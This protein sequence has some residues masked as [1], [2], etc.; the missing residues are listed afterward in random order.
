MH[1]SWRKR[2]SRTI[3]GNLCSLKL[4]GHGIG[5]ATQT[6]N[7]LLVVDPRDFGVSRSLLSRGSYD[8]TAISWLLRVLDQRSRMVFVGAHLGALLVPL[9]LQSGS[10]NIVAFEPNPPTH[11]LLEM[12]LAL[13]GLT[14][15]KLHRLAVGDSEGSIRFTQ[16]RLNSGNSRVSQ[17]GEVVVAMTTL[18]SAL[19]SDASRVDLVVMDTE[20]FEVRALRGASRTLARTRYLYVEYAPEQLVEQG[21]S[22]QE[23]IEMVASQFECMYLPGNP[24]RFFPSRTYV[25][26]LSGLLTRRGLL[27]N[28][29]FTNE[30]SP[31]G[32]LLMPPG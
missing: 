10:R 18:D 9:A 19:E 16:N 17:T 14:G 22:S 8:W 7:G 26:H 25:R 23:F 15:V 2:I 30:T 3:R 31:E 21:S 20:G 5:V 4:S 32:A 12:N 1:I 29:L 6:K 24:P 27:L 11:R 13:N 28:L